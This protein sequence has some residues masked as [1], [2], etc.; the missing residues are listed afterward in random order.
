MPDPLPLDSRPHLA[1]RVRLH[2]DPLPQKPVLLYPEGIVELNDTAHDILT[3]C[4]GHRTVE[5]IVDHLATEYDAPRDVLLPD[6]LAC[7]EDLR[8][9]QLLVP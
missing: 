2:L 4:D 6:I 3:C 7:L 1:P 9:R 5:Q 8:A